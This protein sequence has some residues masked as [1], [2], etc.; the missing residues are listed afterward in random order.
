MSKIQAKKRLLYVQN[1][2]YNFLCYILILTLESFSCY[3]NKKSFK[4]FR[5]IAFI[6]NIIFTKS[7]DD[8]NQIYYRS[9]HT[10]KP[11]TTL[12]LMLEKN[13]VI[14]LEQHKGKTVNIW[15]NKDRLNKRF[16]ELEMFS[17]EVSEINKL[18]EQEPRT[19]SLK[20]SSFLNRIFS[21]HGVEVWEV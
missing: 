18:I 16:S 17:H 9:Q 10:I 2:D 11:L 7:K 8:W 4:D 12:I 6:A 21:D 14:S 3:S 15:L 5:K 19:N 13:G 20:L 1:N